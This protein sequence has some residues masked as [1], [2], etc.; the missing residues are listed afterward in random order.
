MVGGTFTQ[1]ADIKNYKHHGT[2]HRSDFPQQQK[3]QGLLPVA[4][5]LILKTQP[6]KHPVELVLQKCFYKARAHTNHQN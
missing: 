3:R 5:N 4:F 2:T 1:S 6:L